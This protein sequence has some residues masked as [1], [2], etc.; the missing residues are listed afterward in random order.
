MDEGRKYSLLLGLLDG[1]SNQDLKILL[2][3]PQVGRKVSFKLFDLCFEGSGAHSMKRFEQWNG[4]NIHLQSHDGW[5]AGRKEGR[6]AT[7]SEATHT[8]SLEALSAE[9]RGWPAEG[10]G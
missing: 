2:C 8:I 4:T 10:T 1:N 7:S 3:F 5:T 9:Q 6:Q